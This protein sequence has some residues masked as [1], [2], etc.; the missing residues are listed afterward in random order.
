MSRVVMIDELERAALTVST[1]GSNSPLQV[2]PVLLVLV[3]PLEVGRTVDCCPLLGD[4]DD[5]TPVAGEASSR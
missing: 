5:V 2:A 3:L 4:D 1:R